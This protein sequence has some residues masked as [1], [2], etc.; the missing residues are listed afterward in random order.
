VLTKKHAGKQTLLKT[1]PPS[2]RYHCMGGNNFM[3]VQH[4]M[5]LTSKTS[6]VQ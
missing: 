6:L 1:I 3:M 2:L 4:H 5:L